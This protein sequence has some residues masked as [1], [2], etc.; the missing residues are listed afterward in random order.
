MSEY[1]A[2]VQPWKKL[3][4]Q[5]KAADEAAKLTTDG[6]NETHERPFLVASADVNPYPASPSMR[7]NGGWNGPIPA[8]HGVRVRIEKAKL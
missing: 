8:P 4:D 7:M 2:P 1:N 6:E 3:R 5:I